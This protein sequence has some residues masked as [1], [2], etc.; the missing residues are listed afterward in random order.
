MEDTGFL[1]RLDLLHRSL[2]M[3]SRWIH[4][5]A[6]AV[7]LGVG[8]LGASEVCGDDWPMFGRDETRN[9]VSPEKNAPTEWH[10]K[11]WPKRLDQNNK[12][13]ESF[14]DSKNIKWSAQLGSKTLGDPVI[15]DGLVWVGTNNSNPRDPSYRDDASV[16]MC[17]REDDGEFL[18]QYVSPRLPAAMWNDWPNSSLA[19]SPL[20]EGDRMWFATNRCETVCLD[21]GPLRRG[22]GEPKLVW[23]VD[24]L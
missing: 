21:I 18:Y 6:S 19:S 14:D 7:V 8:L 20:V 4:A 24:M 2:T 10:L 15:A 22:E 23:K 16:L 1:S 9:A 13:L 5:V 3:T 12:V 17:F 11:G